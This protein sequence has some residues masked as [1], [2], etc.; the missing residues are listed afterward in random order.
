MK[1]TITNLVLGALCVAPIL[2]ACVDEATP[3]DGLEGDVATDIADSET[4]GD[5]SDI[6]AQP[7]LGCPGIPAPTSWDQWVN[8]NNLSSAGKLY[9]YDDYGTGQCATHTTRFTGYGHWDLGVG[10]SAPTSANACTGVKLTAYLDHL[11]GTGGWQRDTR[12]LHGEWDGT[13]CD[14]PELGGG[15]ADS[16]SEWRVTA[17][18]QTGYCAGVNCSYSYARPFFIVAKPD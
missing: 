9:L 8:L 7:L 18:L 11:T 2:S 10:I 1:N 12:V 13:K 3:D 15:I 4:A 6:D 17:K 14:L 16:Y 5:P